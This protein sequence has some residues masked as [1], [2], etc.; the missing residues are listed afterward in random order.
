M[1]L[2]ANGIIVSESNG[3][4]EREEV[5]Y[6]EAVTTGYRYYETTASYYDYY[7]YH[8]YEY[9]AAADAEADATEYDYYYGFADE[10][11]EE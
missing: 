6:T 4:Y 10:A 7:Y 9:E 5:E 11:I 2:R 1:P 3:G 8:D